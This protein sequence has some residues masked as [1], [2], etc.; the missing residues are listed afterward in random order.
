MP[1]NIIGSTEWNQRGIVL[2]RQTMQE[3][4]NGLVNVQVEYNV[5]A[6]RQSDI[7]KLF[8]VDAPPPI[9][10][11]VVNRSEMLTNNLYMTIRTV[12][13]ANGLVTISAEYVG[14]LVRGGFAGYYLWTE[15][16]GQ[17]RGTA[18]I[19]PA[20]P[21]NLGGAGALL[22]T[23]NGTFPLTGASVVPFLTEIIIHNFE[24]V[25]IGNVAAVSVPV[26]KRNTLLQPYPGKSQDRSFTPEEILAA[27]LIIVGEGAYFSEATEMRRQRQEASKFNHMTPLVKIVTKKYFL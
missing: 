20:T 27:P 7:D 13:R 16:E 11:T 22:I 9:W 10:P 6:T 2:S 14:G 24:F 3:Q 17:T 25:Q 8:Y 26:V 4:L 23:P 19:P 12:E 15:N 1:A 5:P 21:P 18:Y